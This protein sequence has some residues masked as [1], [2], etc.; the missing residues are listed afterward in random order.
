MG[1][2]GGGLGSI[3]KQLPHPDIAFNLLM[4]RRKGVEASICRLLRSRNRSFL[5]V[6]TPGCPE[7]FQQHSRQTD[8]KEPK[9]S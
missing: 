6:L 9:S 2:G 5:H 4:H 8:R 1:G 7:Q 3:R